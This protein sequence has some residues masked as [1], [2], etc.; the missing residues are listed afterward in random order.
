[1]KLKYRLEIWETT[2]VFQVLEMDERFREQSYISTKGNLAIMSS[3][4]PSL[5]YETA[6][7]RGYAKK[8]DNSVA[9]LRFDTPLEAGDYYCRVHESLKNWAENWEGFQKEKPEPELPEENV[10][11]V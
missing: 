8:L 6:W 5:D 10:F 1:M 4:A 9:L 3:V 7:L 11:I 2:V